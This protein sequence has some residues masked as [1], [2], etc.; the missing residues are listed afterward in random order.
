MP[1]PTVLT[2]LDVA[3]RQLGTAL[4]L[5]LEDLDPVSVHTLAGAAAEIS[6]H[7]AREVGATPFIEHALSSNP[8]MTAQRYYGIARQY[9][10]A[11]KHVTG[12]DGGA[13]DDEDLL[14]GFDDRQNDALLFVAW[15]DFMAASPSAPIEAQ[16]FQV[17]FYAS[18]PDKLARREDADRFL[19]AFPRL[20][21]QSRPEQK[22]ELKRQITQAR[23]NPEIMS[24]P[25][26]D[27]SPLVSRQ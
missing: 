7:L 26:T 25:R 12:R 2:K 19:S 16:A 18:Y 24:D 22:I 4:W 14:A 23:R 27:R 17:W 20:K 21:D 10:N 3:R 9:Y 6:E 1:E 5:F 15:I 8:D 13:R 11:F